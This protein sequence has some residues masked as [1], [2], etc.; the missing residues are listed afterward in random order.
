MFVFY[1][2][3]FAQAFELRVGMLSALFYSFFSPSLLFI[4][5][6]LSSI[7]PLLFAQHTT[8]ITTCYP[9]ATHSQHMTHTQHH[10]NYNININILH[11]AKI[12]SGGG[13][14]SNLFYC[15][16]HHF[17]P[18]VLFIIYKKQDKYK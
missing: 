15:H 9:H 7:L 12:F 14:G 10:Q 11:T 16:H 4:I 17:L 3:F 13:G 18:A 6:S 8:H 2:L 1:C 5:H